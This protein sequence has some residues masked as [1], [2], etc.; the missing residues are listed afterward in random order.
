MDQVVDGR[1]PRFYWIDNA[2][3]TQ[4]AR[5]IK[6]GGLAIYNVLCMHADRN[7]EARISLDT[8]CTQTGIETREAVLKYLKLLEERGLITIVR[9]ASRAGNVYRLLDLYGAPDAPRPS[10][11]SARIIGDMPAKPVK[12]AVDKSAKPVD[13]FAGTVGISDSSAQELSV[14]PT[15]VVGISDSSVDGTVG[16]SDSKAQELS[17]FPTLTRLD[18]RLVRPRLIQDDDRRARAGKSSSSP[19]LTRPDLE[20]KYGERAVRMALEIAETAGKPGSLRYARGVLRNWEREG[21][22]PR[23]ARGADPYAWEP[24]S[25]TDTAE[26]VSITD[27]QEGEH[28]T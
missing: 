8:I 19:D 2:V 16:N 12:Q 24:V 14:L 27:G 20:E 11:P 1:T 25:E 18:T 7:Q 9:R 23:R 26:F 5:H 17:E 3:L 10:K 13:N 22:T 28:G 6:P 15:P 4:H 21:T